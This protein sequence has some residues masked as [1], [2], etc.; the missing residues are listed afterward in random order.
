MDPR[1]IG[2]N[3]LKSACRIFL[4]DLQALPDEAF[5]KSFGDKVRTVADI[6]YEVN[7]VNDHAAM[8]I[9]GEKPFDW[10]DDGFVK[11]PADFR[12]KD[13]VIKAF[14][15]TSEKVL[16]DLETF[17]EE[18]F[19]SPIQDEDGQT[20][21]FDRCRFMTLHLWYHS[22]QLNFI[23]TLLGDDGWHWK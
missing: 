17:T 7:M 6:V 13:E 14:E 23:Q 1:A 3:G 15:Q 18:E 4:Q 19:E 5:C 2:I 8:V 10:P 22:G 21:R 12:A 9:R 11:A 16:A 20:T